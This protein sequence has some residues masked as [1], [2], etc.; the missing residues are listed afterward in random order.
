MIS[1]PLLCGVI[2]AQAWGF[3]LYKL[4]YHEMVYGGD[5]ASLL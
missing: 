1:S 4:A 3:V 2:L 5:A